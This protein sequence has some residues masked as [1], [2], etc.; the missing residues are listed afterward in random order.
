MAVS[1]CGAATVSSSTHHL[2]HHAIHPNPH[3]A[4]RADI[5]GLRAVAVLAVVIFHAFPALLPGGFI[6]VDIFFVISGYLISSIIF[7]ALSSGEFSFADFY[8]RRVRRIFPSLLLVIVCTLLLGWASLL[9]DEYAQLGKHALGGLGF[10]ANIVFWSEAGYFDV[11]AELKPLL[12]L[13][14]LGIEEQFYI[15][16]PLIAVLTWRL[17]RRFWMVLVGLAVL[18]FCTNV[19]FTPHAAEASFFLLPTRAWE[20][21]A[22]ALLAYRLHRHGPVFAAGTP[23]AARAAFGGLGVIIA[24][25][26]LID[27]QRA[28]PGWWALLPVGGAVLVI[29]AGEAALPNRAV[30]ARRWMVGIGRI[31]F[32]LYLWH[33]PLLSMARIIGKGESKS[34]IVGAVALAFVCAWVSW[35]VVE[36]PVRRRGHARTVVVLIVLALLCTLGASNVMWR[37]G[38]GF[39]VK[40]AQAKKDTLVLAWG[41]EQLG[42]NKDC[43]AWLPGEVVVNCLIAD[44]ERPPTAALLGDSHANHLYWGLSRPLLAAGVNLLQLADNAC[45]P[46]YGVFLNWEKGEKGNTCMTM[47]NAAI[48]RVSADPQIDTV[49]LGGRW[50]TAILGDELR[51]PGSPVKYRLELPARPESAG[52]TRSEI[53][54]AGLND[55]LARL[56]AAGKKVVFLHGVPE[57]PFIARECIA[58]SPNRFVNRIHHP[59]CLV[60]RSVIDERNAG[61]R[62]VLEQVLARYPQVVVVDPM[63]LMCDEHACYGRHDGTLLYRD[64]DHLSLDG[65]YWLGEQILAVL[66]P[67]GRKR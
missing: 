20:L 59:D 30:L 53:V 9:P 38:L 31:S 22:G 44:P 36:T 29:A 21:L 64:D 16:W 39:R 2:I 65:S 43:S 13:W 66:P 33:W 28:F 18:S 52:W 42:L 61:F 55:T 7:K 15:F 60:A 4:Y 40:N 62:P 14:S 19:V 46:L 57:L 67:L 45:P 41:D 32:P 25:L 17:G 24:G 3:L 51:F 35:R 12:H 63:T 8:A 58:W 5:D 10:A 26:C 50:V 23:A 6:G 47:T 1:E 48:D 11:A 37:D 54:A 27:S 49:F 34:V 56:T